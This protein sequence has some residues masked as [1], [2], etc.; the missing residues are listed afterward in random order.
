MATTATKL[1]PAA[2]RDLAKL[3]NG[4]DGATICYG[5]FMQLLNA[6]LVQPVVQGHPLTLT[7]TGRG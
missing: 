6:G 4:W 1:T 2:R 7:E 5:P 3:R